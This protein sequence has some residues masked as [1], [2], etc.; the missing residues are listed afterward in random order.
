MCQQPMR[1][2]VCLRESVSESLLC[3]PVLLSPYLELNLESILGH[4]IRHGHDA[5]IVDEPMKAS[6][7]PTLGQIEQLCRRE[8]VFGS[9]EQRPGC[10]HNACQMAQVQLQEVDVCFGKFHLDI[11]DGREGF[12]LG[13]RAHVDL[14]TMAG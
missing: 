13:P 3:R 14:G 12:C 1:D 8:S 5:G 4:R 6:F 9:L 10:I 7:F 2:V 11:P